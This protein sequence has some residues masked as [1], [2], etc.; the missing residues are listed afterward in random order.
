[1]SEVDLTTV[2]SPT[3]ISI[4]VSPTNPANLDGLKVSGSTV[5]TGTKGTVSFDQPVTGR[6]VVVW[7]TKL[8]AVPGGGFQGG[9]AEAVVKGG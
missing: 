4:Y 5:V 7:L 1:M 3:S 6:Y 9:I 2:G 8:P